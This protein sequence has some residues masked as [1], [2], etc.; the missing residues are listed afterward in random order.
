MLKSSKER[1]DNVKNKFAYEQLNKIILLFLIVLVI[2]LI[3]E[4]AESDNLILVPRIVIGI[5]QNFT[6][7][8]IAFSGATLF[9]KLTINFFMNYLKNMAQVE[10]KILLSKAYIF[11][12]Y[13]IALII[14]FIYMGIDINNIALSF[15]LAASAFTFAVRDVILSYIIWFMLLTKKPFKI[16][17]Y[18]KINDIEGQVRHIGLFYVVIDANP[19]TYD[20]YTR[21]PNKIFIEMPIHNY[22]RKKFFS[23]FDIYVKNI[24]NIIE[25]LNLIRKKCSLLKEV[26]IKLNLN[27][28]KDGIKVSVE[29]KTTYE[30]REKLRNEIISIILNELNVNDKEI[31][32][33]P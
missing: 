18:I 4:K 22:G 6:I 9:I 8:L 27:S 26:E 31:I 28:D 15:G 17:D 23:T 14:I 11:L 29:F 5:L 7:I 12:V 21:I 1:L 20:D 16:G 24:P 10:E 3:L 32:T 2:I 33:T 19:Q 25:R 13:F 30:N